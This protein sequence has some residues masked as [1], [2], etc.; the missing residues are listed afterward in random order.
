MSY[1]QNYLN[2]DS[3]P[4]RRMVDHQPEELPKDYIDAA[5]KVMLRLGRYNERTGKYNFDIT[6]SKIRSF[7]TLA[8]DIYNVENSRKEEELTE[9]SV[10]KL[11]MMRIRILFEAGRYERE[12]KPFVEQSKIINYL[13]GI[14]TSRQ[15]FIDFSKYLEALVAYHRYLGGRD[16]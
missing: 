11:N 6:T 14:G 5:E 8:N 15:K 7:L 1:N 10:N 2:R 13:K 16:S 12:V 3:H 9:E 4:Q